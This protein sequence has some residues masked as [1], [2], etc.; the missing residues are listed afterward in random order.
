MPPPA[1]TLS[2][3]ADAKRYISRE[4]S[5]NSYGQWST[6]RAEYL[7]SIHDAISDDAVRKVVWMK[8]A[9][10]GAT[11]TLE[12]IIGYHIDYDPCNIL[13][14]QP[15]VTHAQEWSKDSLA[16]LLRDTRC[17]QGKVIEAKTRNS[18]NTIL[19]KQFPGGW[20]KVVG[21]NSPAGFRR[22]TIRVLLF[23]ELDSAPFSA[24]SEGAPLFLA[25]RR[26]RDLWNR[27]IVVVSTPTVTGASAIE[28]EYRFS[29]QE[30]YYV[31]CQKCGA[32]QVLVFS[33]SSPFSKPT[34]GEIVS[35]QAKGY[36]KFDSDNCTWAGYLCGDCGY[37]HAEHEKYRMVA[38]GQWKPLNPSVTETRGFHNNELYSTLGA[39]WLKL[40]QDFLV[41]KHQRQALKV[42]TNTRLA[43]TFEDAEAFTVSD[44]ALAERIERY[45]PLPK[46]CLV[47][48]AGVDVQADRVECAV[49]GWGLEEERWLVDYAILIGSPL[50]RLTMEK[51]DNFISGS[52]K[53]ESGATLPI[54]CCFI[55]AGYAANTAVY[56]FVAPRMRRGVYAVLGRSGK[57]PLV[58]SKYYRDKRTGAISL[59][60][61]VDEAKLRLLQSLHNPRPDLVTDKP[62]PGYVHFNA[63]ATS[64]FFRQLTAEKLV[65][66]WKQ[67]MPIQV[68]DL[69][70]HKRNEALDASVYAYCA[71]EFLR[72]SWRKLAA[73]LAAVK[74]SIDASP[75]GGETQRAE[76]APQVKPQLRRRPPRF[77]SW[78]VNG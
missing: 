13:M 75:S 51:L 57:R 37:I 60:L 70:P 23:D 2:Q 26:L 21:A 78:N 49:W 62:W 29:S 17:L 44:A 36:L 45:P 68:W 34:N 38:A 14:V 47:L 64:E 8:A 39:T 54:S 53:H 19:H 55:D 67:G 74:E 56:K 66:K 48:T 12:N 18:A 31:P 42:F 27:K 59:T 40:A 71:V 6:A 25:E 65:T 3:W 35:P 69:P 7:R 10:L 11:S 32:M 15:T 76:P 24:G 28:Y 5:P 52:W 16:P 33:P 46:N 20:I 43:E 9:G 4:S 50:D 1:M 61:G 41:A 30:H 58:S 77:G 72:P 73:K 63:A 22:I